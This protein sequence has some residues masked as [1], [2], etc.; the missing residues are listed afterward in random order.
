MT[1]ELEN[2]SAADF[3]VTN[4]KQARALVEDAITADR[5]ASEDRAKID[6]QLNGGA[7]YDGNKLREAG[8]AYRSNF[9]P[10][11][12]AAMAQEVTLP[13]HNL[14]ADAP[15]AAEI[16]CEHG[17]PDGLGRY[18]ADE[19]SLVLQD[20]LT[21]QFE[22]WGEKPIHFA[23]AAWESTV[24]GVT[25]FGHR[26]TGGWAPESWALGKA[27]PSSVAGLKSNDWSHIVLREYRPAHKLAVDAEK[28][29]GWNKAAVRKA[30][31]RALIPRGRTNESP[32]EFEERRRSY[33]M[34]ASFD[35]LM[36]KTVDLAHVLKVEFDDK[37]RPSVNY[38]LVSRDDGCEEFLARKVISGH[39]NLATIV[40]A[41]PGY[42]H[43]GVFH[44][45]RGWGHQSFNL[46]KA[47]MRFF[48][49]MNDR[50]AL[51]LALKMTAQNGIDRL[52]AGLTMA[53][54]LCIL[55]EG[56]NLL[57]PNTYKDVQ[58]SLY[59][60]FQTI[61][62][63]IFEINRQYAAQ[64]PNLGADRQTTQTAQL[65]VA[66]HSRVE[67]NVS[68]YILGYYDQVVANVWMRVKGLPEFRERCIK[69]GIPEDR[70]AAVLK[71]VQLVRAPRPDGGGNA[72]ARRQNATER[73]QILE[74]AGVAGRERRM[75]YRNL[76]CAAG[77]SMH[78]VN[79]LLPL[80]P[81]QGSDQASNAR[82]E[83]EVF[84]SRA[85]MIAAGQTPAR[86]EFDPYADAQDHY[87]HAVVHLAALVE[88]IQ[89]IQSPNDIIAAAVQFEEEGA[90][91]IGHLNQ[92]EADKG[93]A[94]AWKAL[95]GQFETLAK[96]GDQLTQKAMAIREE[97]AA[98]Q[99]QQRPE[100]DPETM[101]A[102]QQLQ[103]ERQKHE[104]KMQHR[105][106]AFQQR[107]QEKIMAFR[108]NAAM[109][110]AQQQSDQFP[111]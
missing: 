20:A 55:P 82:V 80:E 52:K 53:G 72:A 2:Y 86:A 99:Q 13:R 98:A 95:I 110:A 4:A 32:Q 46:L 18:E 94:D 62:A 92:A 75:A 77:L 47:Q 25:V 108:Q 36:T 45:M 10:N 93:R 85:A 28:G 100:L 16:R 8:Q 73:I 7:P 33:L 5:E 63:G 44:S 88:R 71:S 65:L 1:T 97:Q 87:E 26:M 81:E 90:H 48:N 57:E 84:A 64:V 105:E 74:S 67:A 38:F 66:Q 58:P 29:A 54:P 78:E 51:D 40:A 42:L 68:S 56:L 76:L 91:L 89:R 14:L 11:T 22:D 3:R 34:T 37:G 107:A 35:H 104:Q 39:D 60:H 6:H 70:F 43:S 69:L 23:R 12:A 15:V 96:V 9:N 19:Y 103:M 83:S 109:K 31:D 59:Q 61:S 106:A 27:L 41:V 24:Y 49:S 50:V 111:S 101:R 102:M 79:Q 30:I 21:R 17:G